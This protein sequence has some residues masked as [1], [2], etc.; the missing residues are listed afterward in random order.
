MDR[1]AATALAN[2]WHE[3]AD[4]ESADR[5]YDQVSR[6]LRTALPDNMT[7]GGATY[8]DDVPTVVAFGKAGVFAVSVTA[9]ADGP[10]PRV[11]VRRL[12]LAPDLISVTLDD[13]PAGTM[14][15]S[16][17]GAHRRTWTFRWSGGEVLTV[18]TLV[19]LYDQWS[20]APTSG[21]SFARALAAELGWHLPDNDR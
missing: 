20:D 19:K 17:V 14:P 16:D 11:K 2:D 1:A 18:G 8:V 3:L 12:P 15:G 21:E 13:D 10:P 5:G 4:R 6:I 7:A 9:G